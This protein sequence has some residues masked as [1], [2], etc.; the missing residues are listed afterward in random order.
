MENFSEFWEFHLRKN[1]K[2]PGKDYKWKELAK[3]RAI[4]RDGRTNYAIATGRAHP[5]GGFLFVFDVDDNSSWEQFK[6]TIQIP[7]TYMVT[8]PRGGKH[9]YVRTSCPLPG[10]VNKLIDGV[11]TRGEGG[12]VVAPGSIIDG[13]S[14]T[15]HNASDSGEVPMLHPETENEIK[16]ILTIQKTE[17]AIEASN[18]RYASYIDKVD[19][20]PQGQRNHGLYRLATRLGDLGAQGRELWAA[21]N[22]ANQKI[23]SPPVSSAELKAVFR[24]SQ[25]TR[26]NPVGV[27]QEK[28][29]VDV[30]GLL[31]N[32]YG[33]PKIE[34]IEEK[35]EEEERKISLDKVVQKL[36]PLGRQIMDAMLGTSHC[37][38]PEMALMGTIT[39]A[40]GLA[41]KHKMHLTIG[42]TVTYPHLYQMIL[43]KTESGKNT[44]MGFI[45]KMGDEDHL[46][47][48]SNG[49]FTSGSALYTSFLDAER[50]D[51]GK[52][53]GFKINWDSLTNT[54]L[55]DEAQRVISL[56]NDGSPNGIQFEGLLNAIMTAQGRIRARGYSITANLPRPDLPY[57]R[58]SL[59]W[60]T[61]P[62]T[63]FKVA[64]RANWDSGLFGRFIILRDNKIPNINYSKLLESSGKIYEEIKS[65]I[66]HNIEMIRQ[67]SPDV[68][69]DVA[70]QDMK[71][72]LKKMEACVNEHRGEI[73]RFGEKIQKVSMGVNFLDS[74]RGASTITDYHFDFAKIYIQFM[75][76]SLGDIQ[77]SVD[78][79]ENE[80]ILLGLQSEFK[81]RIKRMSPRGIPISKLKENSTRLVN[82]NRFNSF[83][84]Q[85]VE[86]GAIDILPGKNGVGGRVIILDASQL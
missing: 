37:P 66:K 64:S 76:Q 29:T 28:G 14:Y 30:S 16:K 54:M 34:L 17:M 20:I 1:S 32:F 5:L 62:E 4:P 31:A 84:N 33:S 2:M 39:L 19:L 78:M 85:L 55:L 65:R 8:T 82:L 49:D 75:A 53:V 74:T 41:A 18:N 73:I 40:C 43:G 11:D 38:N 70:P 52:P 68:G 50:N 27:D 44:P 46:N 25:E 61:Q 67:L 71:S 36:P 12:Y 45:D 57:S 24:S 42:P 15:L 58:A 60:S 9:F 83:L 35:E 6:R 51:K 69:L 59:L 22:Y 21:L 47:F 81:N 72:F 10:S 23:V 80:R 86:S 26:Q 7:E 3:Q 63:F 48:I 56:I 13:K 79:T 77:T